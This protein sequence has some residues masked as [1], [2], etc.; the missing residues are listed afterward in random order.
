[1]SDYKTCECDCHNTLTNELEQACKAIERNVGKILDSWTM[2]FTKRID[3]VSSILTTKNIKTKNNSSTQEVD[4]CFNDIDTRIEREYLITS[5]NIQ[6]M[7]IRARGCIEASL[8]QLENK[9]GAT[10]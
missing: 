7:L 5:D 8:V 9:I 10:K 1:M 2:D 4:R 3:E 6:D